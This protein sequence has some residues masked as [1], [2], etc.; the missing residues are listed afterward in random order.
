MDK[1][2]VLPEDAEQ[3]DGS[4]CGST[5]SLPETVIFWLS[6]EGSLKLSQVKEANDRRTWLLWGNHPRWEQSG[7]FEYREGR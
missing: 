4:Y 1:E 3:R 7:T 6:L 5:S 2:S